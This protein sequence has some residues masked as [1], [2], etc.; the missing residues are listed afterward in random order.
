[1]RT[2]NLQQMLF[3]AT[4]LLAAV[5]PLLHGNRGAAPAAAN[6]SVEWAQ[7]QWAPQDS[8]PRRLPLSALE[9]SFARQFPG[10][11]AR[12]SDGSHQWIVRVIDKPT[13]MLHP[14]ADCFRGLGYKVAPPRVRTD[15]HGEHWRCFSATRD[16]RTLQICERIFDAR[17]GRWTDASSWYW[18]A[19]LS[20]RRANGPWWAVTTVEE[21][22][23]Q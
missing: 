10:H 9:R 1:M 15:R 8:S 6:G 16:G 21:G 12:F 19:L 20:A 2:F 14:A 11:L 18:S 4:L 5:W 7:A 3:S 13:R 23:A 17:G 22:A